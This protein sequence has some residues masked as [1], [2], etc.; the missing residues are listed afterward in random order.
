MSFKSKFPL[1]VKRV[2]FASYSTFATNVKRYYQQ[3]ERRR[4]IL[5]GAY[6]KTIYDSGN[7]DDQD[8]SH[9]DNTD[10][11]DFMNLL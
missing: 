11:M 2:P 1:K 4:N 9:H 7:T 5:I 3:S 6:Q 10:M 8:D